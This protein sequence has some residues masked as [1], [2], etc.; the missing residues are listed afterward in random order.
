MFIVEF[1]TL[2]STILFD[3]EGV[4]PFRFSSTLNVENHVS[5]DVDMLGIF[6]PFKEII[7]S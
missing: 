1:E 2:I 3:I 7:I 4:S 6:K 5:P